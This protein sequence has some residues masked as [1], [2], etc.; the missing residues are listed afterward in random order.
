MYEDYEYD[1]DQEYDY[2]D[3]QNKYKHYFKFD[4]A[5]WDAWGKMLYDA[6]NELVDPKKGVWYNT[7]MLPGFPAKNFPVNDCLPDTM[8]DKYFMCLGNNQYNESIWKAKYLVKNHFNVLYKNHMM[9]HPKHIL[10]QPL[11]YRG[12]FENLN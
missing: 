4:P 3:S 2:E 1:D 7:Y 12:L 8:E 11:F 10:Q 6:L 5:A 9:S